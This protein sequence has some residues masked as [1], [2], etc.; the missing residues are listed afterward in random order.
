MQQ[1]HIM[2]SGITDT[3]DIPHA[4]GQTITLRKL[5]WQHLKEAR[6][7][8]KADFLEEMAVMPSNMIPDMSNRCRKGCGEE[9]HKGACPPPED[10]EQSGIDPADE[11]DTETLLQA[12][13]VSWSYEEPVSKANVNDLNEQTAK[14][15]KAEIVRLNTAPT[16]EEQGN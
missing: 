4:S 3:L 6:A 15:L 11:Y 2:T 1:E 16:E 12:A 14:W 10:G 9:K 13:I 5:S 7:K 8:H